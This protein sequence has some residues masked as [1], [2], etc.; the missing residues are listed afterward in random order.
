[1]LIIY[2]RDPRWNLYLFH[3]RKSKVHKAL[4]WLITNYAVHSH[5]IIAQLPKIITLL[6]VFTLKKFKTLKKK[7][8][9][10]Y[11]KKKT[12][13]AQLVP[14]IRA[15]VLISPLDRISLVIPLPSF[16]YKILLLLVLITT[17]RYLLQIGLSRYI[18]YYIICRKLFL[19]YSYIVSVIV[20]E[21]PTFQK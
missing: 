18:L 7:N 8:S 19:N 20:H 10:L 5:I 14:S 4:L 3:I 21:T 17:L 16:I 9:F 13:L 15:R 6:S 11:V 12:F 2:K 1:M